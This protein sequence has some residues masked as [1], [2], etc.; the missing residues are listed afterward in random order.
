MTPCSSVPWAQRSVLSRC[1]LLLSVVA[2]GIL[3]NAFTERF[4][5]Q[6]GILFAIVTNSLVTPSWVMKEIARRLVN[7]WKFANNVMR[8]YDDQFI[9]SGAKMGF[10]VNA[11]LPQRYQVNKGTALNPVPVVD[12]IVPITLTDQ[13]N[14]GIE[15][16]T[17]SLT[18][19]VDNYREKCIA[20]AVDTL[21]NAVDF[22]GLSRMYKETAKCVGT[23][24]V[25]PATTNA[26]PIYLSAGTK[27]DNAAVPVDDRVAILS[28]GMHAALANANLTVFNPQGDISQ[29]Y[30]KGQ[31]AKEALGISAWFK[32]Q[33]VA[34]HTVGPLGGAPLVDGA[35][36]SGSSILTRAWTA[37]AA[38]RL[39][40]GDVVQFAGCYEI[41]PLNY[42]S[43]G[44]LKD[45]VVTAD[46]D[47][48]A[49]GAATIPI[50][51][52]LIPV[53]QGAL[54][55]CSAMPADGAAVTIFGH[56]STY[57]NAVS[58]QGL[59]YH[60]EAYAMVMADLEL[61]GGLWVSERI[62]NAALGIAV[63]FLK[64]YSIMTDI[65]PARVD[66][67]YGW[68]DTRQELACRVA[69]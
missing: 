45:F 66:L 62:S 14:V 29:I 38:N 48:S 39:L 7:N 30:R 34:T 47:S 15:F 63:R 41:N 33:N 67:L 46:V 21:I 22:D 61:P 1:L 40:Q 51:P 58:P 60:P 23:P 19:E 2:I 35:G 17:A 13:A 44:V 28:S 32:D 49:G 56:A 65:S 18:M 55:T 12:S 5:S 24:G 53:S 11:R 31:F 27:L 37:A 57:A 68:K 42:Q 25:V 59:V 4:T 10:T 43:T 20:P 9:K 26:N 54:A 50:K 36:Q 69:A 16:T 8:S 3:V 6:D 52:D 64:D